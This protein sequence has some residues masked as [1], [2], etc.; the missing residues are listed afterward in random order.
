[1]GCRPPPSPLFGSHSSTVTAAAREAEQHNQSCQSSVL[2]AS[3][4]SRRR[5]A[6]ASPVAQPLLPARVRRFPRTAVS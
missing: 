4:L 6:F 1:M 3:I 2:P 5:Q